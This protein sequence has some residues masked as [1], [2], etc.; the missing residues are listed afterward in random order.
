MVFFNPSFFHVR[1]MR[2]NV[3]EARQGLEDGITHANDYTMGAHVSIGHLAQGASRGIS[4]RFGPREIGFVYGQL[5]S[6]TIYKKQRTVCHQSGPQVFIRAGI[7]GIVMCVT[8]DHQLVPLCV[9]SGVLVTMLLWSI[10]RGLNVS[11][12]LVF[13]CTYAMT[14]PAI[15]A[16]EELFCGILRVFALWSFTLLCGVERSGAARLGG[17]VDRRGDQRE[18]VPCQWRTG[19]ALV[20]FLYHLEPQGTCTGQRQRVLR[21]PTCIGCHRIQ[22]PLRSLLSRPR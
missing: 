21:T 2:V 4:A 14:V 5:G 16:R 7:N 13:N 9:T 12:G 11:R 19:V 6:H 15:P 1:P 10:A 18:W 17:V 3:P 22:A 8:L 20:S